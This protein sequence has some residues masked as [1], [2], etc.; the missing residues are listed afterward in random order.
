LR[1]G[2][3]RRSRFAV[4]I[5]GIGIATIALAGCTTSAPETEASGEAEATGGTVV[6]AEVNEL[7][8]LNT[9]TPD[10]NV[11]ING[12]VQYLTSSGFT[13]ISD[14]LD[15]IPDETFGT[16][17]VLSEDPLSVEYTI[18]EDQEWSDGEP[19]TASDL[20][21]GFAIHSGWFDD[22]SYDPETGEV[23]E[24]NSYFT[25]AGDT[26][27]LYNNIEEWPEVGDDNMSVT[28]N[29][30][31]PFADYAL[32]TLLDKPLHIAAEEAGVSVEDA[33]AA[34]TD[35]PKGDVENPGEENATI[36]ALADFWN[37]GY[38]MT[39]MPTNEN[40]LVNSGPFTLTAW[41]PTQ[42]ITLERNE[43]YTGGN[44]ASID[45]IVIRFI[46]DPN[47]QVT[48]L[49]NGEVDVIAPQASADTLS[50][51]E[52]LEGVETLV[53][54]QF[55]YDHIDLTFSGVFKDQNVREAFL[56]TIPRQQILDAIVTPLNP[57]AAVLDSQIFVPTQ[58][59][60]YTGS[61]ASNG[62]SEYAEVDIEGAKALL[63][64]ATPKVSILYNTENP[65]RVDAFQAI[66]T[67]AEE[68]GFIIEDAGSPDWGELLGSGTYDASIFGWVSSGVGVSGVPQIF[69]GQGG[70]NYNNYSNDEVNALA[71]ELL[72]T[73]E[74]DE[75]VA[76]QQ[77]IDA[78]LFADAY[79]LPLF[80][81][82]GI[83]AFA[84]TVSGIT[85]YPGQTGVFWNYFDWTVNE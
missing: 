50:A 23:T 47:A 57:E 27:G 63:D 45:S 5:A 8:S 56:K 31:Q 84:D 2:L 51:L 65:N 62:S 79:G 85:H 81:G 69:A 33:E 9:N 73:V 66:Q 1:N 17:E 61:I 68:A 35:A 16:M 39:E 59:E 80:Q 37:T 67:S 38:D 42:S 54:D 11:D 34:L 48:A 29:Y 76:I 43:S 25:Y 28:I 46:G 21:F 26:T 70:G 12:K 24:G 18:N 3:N 58:G 49:Q 53:G 55:S 41:E 32:E 78:M 64:G 74:P 83:T 7:T 6:V 36:R 14:E 60:S 19:I 10:G 71:D 77:Q 82:P 44:P 52:N 22:A 72:V 15:I 13:Y 20:L 75:Q 30:A 4:G 40:L